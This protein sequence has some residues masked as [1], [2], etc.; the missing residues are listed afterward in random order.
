MSSSMSSCLRYTRTANETLFHDECGSAKRFKH[1][2]MTL[3]LSIVAF[4][5]L[6]VPFSHFFPSFRSA[7]EI[8]FGSTNIFF[9]EIF[10]CIITLTALTISQ[11]GAHFHTNNNKTN[12]KRKKWANL[13]IFVRCAFIKS[14]TKWNSNCT[15]RVYL[16]RVMCELWTGSDFLLPLR[17]TGGKLCCR[18]KKDSC[19][20]SH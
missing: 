14:E 5:R 18:E 12:K 16:Y 1:L 11:S 20:F 4:F 8:H 6:L 13:H 3:A 9:G 17:V 15:F 7:P 2:C 19:V 10:L